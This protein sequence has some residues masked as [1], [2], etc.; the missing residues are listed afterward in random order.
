[1]KWDPLEYLRFS[2]ER[3]R[4]FMDLLA[5]MPGRRRC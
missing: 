4:P 1:M 3:G 2:D 5:R